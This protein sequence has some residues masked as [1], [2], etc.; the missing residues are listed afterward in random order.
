MNIMLWLIVVLVC[1][2]ML[3][4]LFYY[5]N[6]YLKLRYVTYKNENFPFTK[7]CTMVHLSDLHNKKFG[8]NQKRLIKRLK[9]I[10]PDFI[11]YTGDLI[12]RLNPDYEVAELFIKEIT[13]ICPVYYV[14]GNHEWAK[15]EYYPKVKQIL[16]NYQV[17]ELED[18]M[19]YLDQQ[20]Q[21]GLYGLSDPDKHSKN[22]KKGYEMQEQALVSLLKQYPSKCKILLTHR[23]EQFNVYAKHHI[24]L[25]C[26]GHAHGGQVRLPLTDGLYAPEQGVLPK[27]TQG[28]Y[29]KQ[30][31]TMNVSRGLGKSRGLTRVFNRPEIVVIQLCRK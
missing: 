18:T 4:G 29:Q 10:Q 31:T 6:S 30:N 7:P 8:N 3:Y 24:D 23:P 27:Y 14:S 12:W 13:K 17:I 25:V 19:V 11:V 5:H 20:K 9:E 22:K 1:I 15:K 16:E 28:P 2:K 21:C 26:S